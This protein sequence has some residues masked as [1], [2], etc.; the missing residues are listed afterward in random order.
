MC[1]NCLSTAEVVAA[2]AA[3]AVYAA[4]PP[5]RRRMAKLG[6]VAERDRVAHD[7]RTLAFLR[8]LDLDPVEILGREIVDAAAAWTPQPSF[9]RRRFRSAAPIGSQR[10][11]AVQ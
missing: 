2:Q 11:L 5:I 4:Q 6:L 7:V 3:F 1:V 10:R 8:D 9:T